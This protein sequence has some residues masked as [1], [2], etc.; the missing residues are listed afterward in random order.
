VPLFP[1]AEDMQSPKSPSNKRYVPPSSSTKSV[2]LQ[3]ALDHLRAVQIGANTSQSLS[4]EDLQTLNEILHLLQ[5]QTLTLNL[6]EDPGSLEHTNGEPQIASISKGKKRL[7]P[8]LL[9]V[10]PRDVITNSAFTSE[11][12]DHGEE[13]DVKSVTSEESDESVDI[14][15]TWN[16]RQKPGTARSAYHQ[17]RQSIRVQKAHWWVLDNVED[18]DDEIVNFDDCD[19]SDTTEDDPNENDEME[20]E[21]ELDQGLSVDECVQ[22]IDMSI[23]EFEKLWDRKKRPLRRADAHRYWLRFQSAFQRYEASDALRRQLKH[24]MK[25]LNSI[26]AGLVEGEKSSRE[27]LK[28]LCGSLEA[29]V[30]EIQETRFKVAILDAVEAPPPV[31]APRRKK[32]KKGVDEMEP[33]GLDID[34]ESE[35][36]SEDDFID[37]DQHDGV[38]GEKSDPPDLLDETMGISLPT[39]DSRYISSMPLIVLDLTASDSEPELALDEP[40]AENVMD[41]SVLSVNEDD[42]SEQDRPFSLANRAQNALTPSKKRKKHVKESQ[43]GKNL[44]S[45]N[46]QRFQ[47]ESERAV[48]NLEQLRKDTSFTEGESYVI[49]IGKSDDE[50][51]IFLNQKASRCIKKH[52]VEG[53]QFLWREIVK[54]KDASKASGC[55]LSHTMGLGK[56]FQ[57][58]TLLVTIQEAVGSPN[59]SISCQIPNDIRESRTLILCPPNLVQNWQQEILKW[60]PNPFML[61]QVYLVEADQSTKAREDTIRSWSLTKGVLIIGFSL[62]RQFFH[63]EKGDRLTTKLINKSTN[64]LIV[65]EAHHLKNP[66][67]QL[68][69][70]ARGLQV[71]RRIA[72]TGTPLSNDLEEYWA[73]IDF[74]CPGYLGT[75]VEFRARYAEPIE[76]GNC[77]DSKTHERRKAHTRLKALEKR[78]EPKVHRRDA[79]VLKDTLPPLRDHIIKI[80]LT[81]EQKAAYNQYVDLFMPSEGEEIATMSFLISI[82]DLTL[83]CN[84]PKILHKRLTE[85]KREEKQKVRYIESE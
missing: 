5:P 50:D 71:N 21:L 20:L 28:R 70:A 24:L 51:F 46:A 64:L 67:S 62:F 55:L 41:T 47:E 78:L 60:A 4:P 68:S 45:K 63:S 77:K 31:E 6:E 73:M 59:K 43:V 16:P 35:V 29:T 74:T 53:L 18:D 42:D 27:T 19:N 65:D 61:G 56:T 17:Y 1:S 37:I 39:S 44:R 49:N 2:H 52:Q 30:F 66:S 82:A 54:E 23:Q 81:G 36:D 84:H 3:S 26:K 22:I 11:E 75:N 48:H 13:F 14:E 32:T 10:A 8:T 34:S 85:R 33:D 80:Q 69:D 7:A 9:N 38:I 12:K 76:Q 15:H 58:I 57:A 25:R 40:N 72:L 83:L 79:T